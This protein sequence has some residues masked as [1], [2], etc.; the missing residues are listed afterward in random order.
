MRWPAPAVYTGTAGQRRQTESTPAGGAGSPPLFCPFC[1][2]SPALPPPPSPQRA[3]LAPIAAAAGADSN[4]GAIAGPGKAGAWSG[5]I[6][7]IK[8][9]I[10][11]GRERRDVDGGER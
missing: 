11:A 4:S 2:L 9:N 10:F 6:C 1:R 7:V 8:D 3:P 5:Y